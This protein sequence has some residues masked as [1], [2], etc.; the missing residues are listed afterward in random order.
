MRTVDDFDTDTP[1]QEGMDDDLNAEMMLEAERDAEQYQDDEYQALQAEQR[2]QDN[3]RQED[4]QREDERRDGMAREQ[5]QSREDAFRMES[6][7]LSRQAELDSEMEFSMDE[8]DDFEASDEGQA[9]TAQAANRHAED[10]SV[11]RQEQLKKE[12][13]R[14]LEDQQSQDS[15]YKGGFTDLKGNQVSARDVNAIM[16]NHESAGGHEAARERFGLEND[17]GST[18][19]RDYYAAREASPAQQPATVAEVTPVQDERQANLLREVERL[20]PRD[21]QAATAPEQTPHAEDVD[22]AKYMGVSDEQAKAVSDQVRAD[23]VGG[24]L[25]EEGSA[26]TSATKATSLDPMSEQEMQVAELSERLNDPSTEEGRAALENN[27][28][29][30]DWEAELRESQAEQERQRAREEQTQNQAM[31]QT[32]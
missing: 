11:H 18:L 21:G 10:V 20:N 12:A 23:E 26:S 17:K 3:Q 16:A 32:R 13:D 24:F 9:I 15:F 5:D 2:R 6:E 30:T 19:S 28:E 7:R 1:P 31:Q 29:S 25:Q 4:N 8:P 14:A 27:G 22:W